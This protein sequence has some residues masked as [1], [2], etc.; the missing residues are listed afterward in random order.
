MPPRDGVNWYVLP[1]LPRVATRTRS[2]RGVRSIS[3]T[4]QPSILSRLRRDETLESFQKRL[5]R[6]DSTHDNLTATA[7]RVMRVLA[8]TGVCP[9]FL[10]GMRRI[11]ED[12]AGGFRVVVVASNARDVEADLRRA[13]VEADLRRALMPDD[14][15]GVYDAKEDGGGIY[16]III[17]ALV[18][19]H[20]SAI[21]RLRGE[22]ERRC[23]DADNNSSKTDVNF[24]ARVETM[25]KEDATARGVGGGGGGGGGDR[26][27]AVFYGGQTHSLV[28]RDRARYNE[29]SLFARY[30][31][32]LK[33]IAGDANVYVLQGMFVTDNVAD[34]VFDRVIGEYE[35][36]ADFFNDLEGL[37]VALRRGMNFDGGL[38][39]QGVGG[40]RQ[41]GWNGII[42]PGRSMARLV[43]ETAYD[44]AR[45]RGVRF[46]VALA[47]VRDTPAMEFF[48]GHEYYL[49]MTRTLHK[50]LA[51][52]GTVDGIYGLASAA[53]YH[54]EHVDRPVPELAEI[55]A[56][57]VISWMCSEA[58]RKAWGPGGVFFDK[59]VTPPKDECPGCST[60]TGEVPKGGWRRLPRNG[61]DDTDVVVCSWCYGPQSRARAIADAE[62]KG[63]K[64]A[65]E[66]CTRLGFKTPPVGSD[67]VGRVCFSCWS[68]L[69]T[70]TAIAKAKEKG[71]ECAGED[72]DDWGIL[73]SPAGGSDV[74][75]SCYG[76]LRRK[77]KNAAQAVL[78]QSPDADAAGALVHVDVAP[79][80]TGRAR[81]IR[82]GRARGERQVADA[83]DQAWLDALVLSVSAARVRL[84]RYDA[85][86][87]VI[88]DAVAA[89]QANAA[90]ARVDRALAQVAARDFA[91]MAPGDFSPS[92]QARVPGAFSPAHLADA[93]VRLE[94]QFF[95]V[96]L[97]IA[98]AR[99]RADDDQAWLAALL[100]SVWAARVRLERIE[101]HV[102]DL[103]VAV[104][105]SQADAAAA[106]VA[107]RAFIVLERDALAR[108]A[109]APGALKTEE[110]RV[111][112][113]NDPAE[114]SWH[115][116]ES[117]EADDAD[118]DDADAVTSAGAANGEQ[119]G[120]LGETN[121]TDASG[122]D[123]R[124]ALAP[125]TSSPMDLVDADDD[126][127]PALF[128]VT[129]SP[130]DPADAVVR[131]LEKRFV[132]VR[133]GGG[134][135][136][137]R[138]VNAPADETART[139]EILLARVNAPADERALITKLAW[140]R[141]AS[142]FAGAAD[143]AESSTLFVE[144]AT[145]ALNDANGRITERSG[146]DQKRRRVTRDHASGHETRPGTFEVDMP[147]VVA[148][149]AD[150]VA[151]P[152]LPLPAWQRL[153]HFFFS[154]TYGR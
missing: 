8:E 134:G 88:E 151:P 35:S 104:A 123:G 80:S 116:S 135:A 43:R 94:E 128:P 111:A 73:K 147:S 84:E 82:A 38:N 121:E 93:V 118:A 61:D 87:A 98:S 47:A 139:T 2:F 57:D 33:E 85:Y 11:R 145:D 51:N 52:A 6:K 83:D 113:T 39:V 70:E 28:V 125:G 32:L 36:Y 59:L 126:A 29:G 67:V 105:A 62:E 97:A 138:E 30:L 56:E 20:E 100:A 76:K 17:V 102:D 142:A 119:R 15:Y 108:D 58:M 23:E 136:N 141:M 101:A 117:V 46:R 106:E 78:A 77:K 69:W 65:G 124:D 14:V 10:E 149:H 91:V 16:E 1:L 68:S 131:R 130:I 137:L 86:V 153:L 154:A 120:R 9:P 71:I 129:S 40:R 144:P 31:Q 150:V 60:P 63:I 64:C 146:P 26:Y 37:S 45:L 95:A 22:F 140:T 103:A 48:E 42:P 143:D 152:P 4:V 54:A 7:A 34:A 44:H 92:A 5:R 25:I 55:R 132:A 148:R 127:S 12:D 114:D 53:R 90:A 112:K 75:K 24:Y 19:H 99:E 110:A 13:L 3:L 27:G 49:E 122:R 21:A 133:L 72:C 96:W 79:T 81:T 115:V 66:K 18:S 74:C 41:T 107:A 109:L 50:H 89:S